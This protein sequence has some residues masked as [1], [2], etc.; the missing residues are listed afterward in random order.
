[1]KALF[2]SIMTSSQSLTCFSYSKFIDFPQHQLF[3]IDCSSISKPPSKQSLNN[4]ILTQNNQRNDSQ[5]K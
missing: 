2:S 3:S 5:K 4:D 1:M